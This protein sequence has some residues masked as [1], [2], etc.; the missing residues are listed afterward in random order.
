MDGTQMY[1]LRSSHPQEKDC[2]YDSSSRAK[3]FLLNLDTTANY[4]IRKGLRGMKPFG[5]T[6]R[7]LVMAMIE[8]DP[9]KRI[10]IDEAVE[11]FAA[12][13]N[14]LSARGRVAYSN[15]HFVMRP[16][17]AISHWVWTLKLIARRIPAVPRQ[18]VSLH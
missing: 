18:S 12:I 17:R 4:K 9:A 2:N 6:V 5:F 15:E 7:P 16:F 8:P 13:E 1:G 10:K 11:G 14:G 3:H